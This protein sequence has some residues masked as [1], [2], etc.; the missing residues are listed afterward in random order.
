M[1]LTRRD[2]FLNSG[3][4]GLTPERAGRPAALAARM[5]VSSRNSGGAN[6]ARSFGAPHLVVRG[7]ADLLSRCGEA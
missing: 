4:A 2:D 3:A 1:R 6:A 7:G 5:G